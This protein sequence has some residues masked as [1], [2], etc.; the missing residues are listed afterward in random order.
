MG[1]QEKACEYPYKQ[2]AKAATHPN[3]LAKDEQPRLCAKHAKLAALQ[4]GQN[5]C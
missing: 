1:E 2:C 3:A 5:S 4:W